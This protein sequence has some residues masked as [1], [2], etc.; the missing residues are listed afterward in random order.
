[1]LPTHQWISSLLLLMTTGWA[2]ASPP[3]DNE[4]LKIQTTAESSAY[5]STSSYA[6]VMSFLNAVATHSPHV[7]VTSF[8]K[9]VEGRDLPLAMVSSGLTDTSPA[10]IMGSRKL[11]VH[12]QANVHANEADGKE[13]LLMLLR[14]LA[15]GQHD[16]WL[17]SMV[18]LI[19]PIVNVDGNEDISPYNR[20][21]QNGPANGVGTRYQAQDRDINRDYMKLET[22]EARAIVK[23][24]NEYDPHISMDL[25]TSGCTIH[26]YDLTYAPPLYPDTSEKILSLLR[27]SW[28][29]AI[30]SDIKTRYGRDIFYYGNIMDLEPN[31]RRGCSSDY[32]MEMAL[33]TGPHAWAT[34]E[35]K[36][37]FHNNYVGLRNRFALLGET[38]GYLSFEERIA[39]AKEFIN[40]V[41]TFANRNKDDIVQATA[42][43]DLE[44]NSGQALATRAAREH[45]GKLDIRL[46]EIDYLYD[47][48]PGIVIYQK[49]RSNKIESMLNL[50]WFSP[51]TTE[52]VPLFYFIPENAIAT[53]ELLRA[54][55]IQLHKLS[56]PV[57]DVEEFRIDAGKTVGQWKPS[58]KVMV[59]AGSWSVS[60]D[61]P[62]GRVAFN[63]LAPTSDDG[64][65]T[66][67][68]LENRLA[69]D[70][71]IYPIYRKR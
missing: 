68:V 47:K 60:M 57:V 33:E 21:H 1:M 30:T 26:G 9:S 44:K 45:N 56:Q 6:E 34:F 66:L 14:E 58:K 51:T 41:L 18:F 52:K 69:G 7:L 25:H 8:G 55:G 63:L 23:L 22:P 15:T 42:R 24:L 20:S 39:T 29:P 38:Y 53:L 11:R 32:A 35:H 31:G 54:H 16:D 10:G 2:G 49:K 62:M 65:M 4:L 17:Q 40:S 67:G 13:A 3:E 28:F 43:A 50:L 48:N 19:T 37:R 71:K 5:T 27:D 46:G 61:Q 64:L 12:L 59:P 36:P 70:T